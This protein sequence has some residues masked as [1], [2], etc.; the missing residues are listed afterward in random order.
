M[1]RPRR[2]GRDLSSYSLVH[3]ARLTATGALAID[4]PT[5]KKLRKAMGKVLRKY[6][7]L[8]SSES[9]EETASRI[10][11]KVRHA[12]HHDL[13]CCMQVKEEVVK[14]EPYPTVRPAIEEAEVCA[15]PSKS[16][17]LLK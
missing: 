9:E 6:T 13:L 11:Q 2:E 3:R 12:P 1:P 10:V 15:L 5:R 8:S 14:S 16:A 7:V 17:I 4:E